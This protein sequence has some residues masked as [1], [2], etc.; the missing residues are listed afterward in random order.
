MGQSIA[1]SPEPMLKLRNVTGK[2]LPQSQRRGVHQVG[3]S[4]FHNLHEFFGLGA[5][6][7]LDLLHTRDG[8]LK[9]HLVGG[10]V[11]S[12]RKGIV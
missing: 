4:D 12:G 8:G 6:R 2:L 5:Q 9:E 11:H 1:Q 10:D 7:I 3:S